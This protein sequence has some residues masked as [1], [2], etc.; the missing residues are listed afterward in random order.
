ML[1]NLDALIKYSS[2]ISLHFKYNDNI[3]SFFIE[4]VY[5]FIRFFQILLHTPMRK[6]LHAP[7]LVAGSAP[8]GQLHGWQTQSGEICPMVFLGL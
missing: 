5:N 7:L 3:L 6:R 2:F 1:H 8:A 4:I